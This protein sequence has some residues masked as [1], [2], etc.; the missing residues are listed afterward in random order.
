MLLR[1]R[2]KKS[3]FLFIVLFLPWRAFA[4]Y[5]LSEVSSSRYVIYRESDEGVLADIRFSNHDWH[6][7]C[8]NGVLFGSNNQSFKERDMA[9]NIAGEQCKI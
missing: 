4:G 5:K 7:N 9:I 1:N 2:M 8:V 3:L 6:L